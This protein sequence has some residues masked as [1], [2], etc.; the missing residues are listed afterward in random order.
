M[1]SGRAHAVMSIATAGLTY[2]YS[3]NSGVESPRLA[4]ATASGCLLGIL[5]TPD[6]DVK[7]IR[8]DSIVR[9]MG[10][11]PAL[12][13]GIVWNPYS[14]LFP[15]RSFWTHSPLLGTLIRFIYIGIWLG[16]FGLLPR[17]GPFV[18]RI[19]LG[20]T[21]SDNIHIGADF[22]V[23]GIKEIIS[24]EKKK[25]RKKRAKNRVQTN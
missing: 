21:M 2:L 7:G 20:V 14:A 11:I 16:V 12:I 23:T 24:N 25:R 19:I 5:L 10:L 1:P 3:T 18:C 17:P 22:F 9:D 6:L 4:V 15:H 13:W 8:A